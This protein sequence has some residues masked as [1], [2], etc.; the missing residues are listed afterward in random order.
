M[1]TK[2][3]VESKTT[4]PK[5]GE[6]VK[7][8]IVDVGV[9]ATSVV[10]MCNFGCDAWPGRNNGQES[11]SALQGA[12]H[13]MKKVRMMTIVAGGQARVAA[14]AIQKKVRYGQGAPTQRRDSESNGD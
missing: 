6:R 2:K 11:A 10:M 8:V 13:L 1:N 9:A 12:T 3:H 5:K 4:V 7:Y 14:T